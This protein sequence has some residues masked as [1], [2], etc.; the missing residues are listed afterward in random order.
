MTSITPNLDCYHI[1]IVSYSITL[2]VKLEAM[3]SEKKGGI[4]IP[5]EAPPVQPQ[6]EVKPPV[7]P[8]MPA[9][10]AEDPYIKPEERP[11]EISPYDLPPPG[12]NLFPEIF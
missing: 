6:P 1:L 10:P 9:I 12:E 8:V 11:E 3:T 7:E 4:A 2:Q 5:K